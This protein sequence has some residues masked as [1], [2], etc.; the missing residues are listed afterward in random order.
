MEIKVRF[1]GVLA[2]IAGTSFRHYSGVSSFDD[3][4]IRINDDCPEIAFYD[5]RISVNHVLVKDTPVIEGDSEIA[6]V[7]PFAGG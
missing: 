7:P 1:F 5:Y 6:F 2:E 4:M 3:L